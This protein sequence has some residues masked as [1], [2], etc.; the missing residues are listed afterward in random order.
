M[1]AIKVKY[2][3]LPHKLRMEILTIALENFKKSPQEH[4]IE[5]HILLNFENLSTRS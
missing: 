3:A 2:P 4:F 5:K 1:F